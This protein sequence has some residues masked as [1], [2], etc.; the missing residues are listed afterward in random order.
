M[1]HRKRQILEL[2]RKYENE[3]SGVS[4]TQNRIDAVE[5]FAG[6]VKQSGHFQPEC[7]Q[8]IQVGA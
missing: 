3:R 2:D 1:W 8:S 4:V 5:E 7:F 6:K